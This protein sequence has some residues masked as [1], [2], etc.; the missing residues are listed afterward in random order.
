MCLYYFRY[1]K[2]CLYVIKFCMADFT[3]DDLFSVFG[4]SST[5]KE[6]K[7]RHTK[8]TS[9]DDNEDVIAADAKGTL[10]LDQNGHNSSPDNVSLDHRST[11]AN[12]DEI[13]ID[14]DDDVDVT[15]DV[16][17]IVEKVSLLDSDVLSSRIKSFQV[18]LKHANFLL[19]ISLCSPL[20]TG[21]FA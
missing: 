16:V 10:D 12:C 1:I 9:D 6:S 2:L 8:F 5:P 4:V 20:H 15:P 19:M 18:K 7:A 21:L 17:E 14:S 11:K 3:P 13:V